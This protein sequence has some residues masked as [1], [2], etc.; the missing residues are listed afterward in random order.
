MFAIQVMRVLANRL[1]RTTQQ[2]RHS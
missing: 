2:Q 1:R